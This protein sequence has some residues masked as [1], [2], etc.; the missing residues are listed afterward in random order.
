[1]EK[2]F[3]KISFATLILVM[4]TIISIGPLAID[5]YLPAFGQMSEYFGVKESKIELT[6]SA[7]FIGIACG[8]ILYGPLIDRFGKKLP[9]IFGLSIFVISSLFC[10][11]S[12]NINGI[13]FLRFAQAIGSCACLVTTRAIVRDL[14]SG[15]ELAQVFSYLILITGVAPMIAPFLGGIILTNFG[16]QA[17]FWCLAG[18]A[19]LLII[20]SWLFLPETS[21]KKEKINFSNIKKKYWKIFQDKSFLF[22]AICGGFSCCGM[23][24][25]I[26]TSSFVIIKFFGASD[27]NYSLIFGLNG[28]GYV[29]FAQLNGWFL[30]FFEIK[31]ILNSAFKFL[32]L[33]SILLILSGFYFSNLIAIS[34]IFFLYIS[35][36]GIILPNATAIALSNQGENSGS[37]SALFGTLQFIISALG[38]SLISYFHNQTAL[39]LLFAAAFCGIIA[40]LTNY[41]YQS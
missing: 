28:L 38:S 20:I 4:G 12:N 14:F 29:I 21:F 19:V 33:L 13:I 22:Y 11:T 32:L 8:Q 24:I 18:F 9:L 7:Y 34:I 41:I 40:F 39:P 31:Q 26:T 6:L 17:I 5:M 16:W 2:Q 25:Y 30:K 27:K 35:L 37:A 36:I 23:F 1:M 3:T 10:A 15:K